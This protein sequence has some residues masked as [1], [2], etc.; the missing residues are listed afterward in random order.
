MSRGARPLPDY[1]G[2]MTPATG[3]ALVFPGQG[4][5][6]VGMGREL[7]DRFPE[8]RPL[9]TEADDALGE[10]L[11]R[12]CFTGPD[13]ELQQGRRAQPAIVTVS[14]AIWRVI[15]GRLDLRVIAASG[16]SLGQY[17][18][19]VASGAISLADALRLVRDRALCMD[20]AAR[21][22]SGM[23]AII[24]LD[25]ETVGEICALASQCVCGHAGVAN[26]NCPGQVVV[27]GHTSVL[28]K[29]ERLA[30]EHGARYAVRLAMAVA[31]H[32]PLMQPAAER[33]AAFVARTPI[34]E[35]QFPVVGNAS[36]RP[37]T[38]PEDIRA[39]L[40]AQL[41]SPVRWPDVVAQ[42]SLLGAERLWEIGPK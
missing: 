11:S 42:L 27:A 33:F 39:E 20:Q 16:H 19:L 17:S 7:Y 40:P 24:G 8:V 6:S 26:Y 1:R 10:P 34:S 13:E 36:L 37:V 3:L 32:S 15:S 30:R 38:T 41:V 18:A 9:F 28:E 2:P 5:Q 35:A 31:S 14:I 21:E 25:D 29:V 22:P 23:L 4:T 12:I